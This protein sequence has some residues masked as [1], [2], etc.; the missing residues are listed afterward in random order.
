MGKTLAREWP[1]WMGAGGF[2][3]FA[4]CPTYAN[5]GQLA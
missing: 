2:S 4:H 3:Y 5:A 1:S